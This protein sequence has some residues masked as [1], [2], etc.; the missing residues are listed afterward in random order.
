MFILNATMPGANC[1]IPESGTCQR[2]KD[3]SLC[4]IKAPTNEAKKKWRADLLNEITKGR[5]VDANFRCQ[6][7][8]DTFEFVRSILKLIRYR[9]VSSFIQHLVCITLWFQQFQVENPFSRPCP[10]T[11]K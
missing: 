1:C 4:K 8:N 11:N 2:H 7:L 10:M 6:I 5:E 9:H 3:L